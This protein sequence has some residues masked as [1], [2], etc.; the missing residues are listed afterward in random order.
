[1]HVLVVADRGDDDAGFVGE[2]LAQR[3]GELRTVYRDALSDLGPMAP[4]DLVLLLGSEDAVHDQTRADVVAAES[5]LVS[6]AL[7]GGA[8]VLAICYGA[9]LV[10]HTLGGSVRPVVRGE[11]GWFEVESLDPLLCPVGPW[12]QFH[13]D[14]FAPPPGARVTG[15][16]ALGPQGFALDPVSGRAGVV[17]WQ[18]HPETTP[19]TL[20][21]WVHEA[22]G[23]VRQHGAD[24][25]VFARQTHARAEAARTAAH[26]LVDAALAHLL[27]RA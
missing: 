26:Q 21:R 22:N 25:A 9:Q 5:A 23:Y 2:R 17:A 1:M 13:S 19:S 3:G 11:V 24:P 10:A 8:P 7:E 6:T 16:S 15:R 27:P 12:L 18:F 14:V 4:F 20:D